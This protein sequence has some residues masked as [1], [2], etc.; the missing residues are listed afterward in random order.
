[1]NSMDIQI[2]NRVIGDDSEI[3]V[4]AE[5]GINHNGKLSEAKKLID[6]AAACGADAVKFQ[7]FRADQLL[8][9]SH[10]RYIRRCDDQESAYRMLR[11]YELNFDE[12]ERLKKYA[13]RKGIIFMSTP[14]D[15]ESAD[16]LDSMGV[17]AFKIASGDIT[18]MPLLR[19]IAAK[20]KPIFL[21]TGMSFLNEVTDA[22]ETLRAYGAE[23]IL[24]MHC[25]SVYHATPKD[26]N[27]RAM[28]T[29]RSYFGLPVGLSD[30]S[31]GELFSIMAAAMG[32]R[33]IEKHFTLNKAACGPEHRTSMNPTEMKALV[34][35]LKDVRAGLG[36]KGK[37][38]AES[39]MEGRRLGRRSIVAAADIRANEPIASWML[40]FKRPGTGLEPKFTEQILGM[41]ARRDIEKDEI[42]QWDDLMPAVDFTKHPENFGNSRD[43]TLD[44]P[45]AIENYV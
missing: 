3:F 28:E 29:M 30:H 20:G 45:Y 23:E 17:P 40:T 27:L 2:G 13:D 38:P 24:L 5:I 1:M 16:F 19:H 21:S 25:A 31:Q 12:Q 41:T 32:A 34:Q 14:F 8:I 26:I 42:L 36:N 33:V 6:E 11:R 9:S 39:E 44:F 15:E 35:S 22:L 18:H 10:D 7:S 37:R 43:M 4:I